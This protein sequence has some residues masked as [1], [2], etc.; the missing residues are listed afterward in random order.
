M[1]CYYCHQPATVHRSDIVDKEKRE[2]H[3]CDGCARGHCHYCGQPATDNGRMQCRADADNGATK[4]SPILPDTDFGRIADGKEDRNH[5][6]AQGPDETN[7]LD[8]SDD[9]QCE[10]DMDC[11][12]ADSGMICLNGACA[13]G[14]R[15]MDGNG[16]AQGQR[17]TSVNGEAGMC[18]PIVKPYFGGG[19]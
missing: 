6:G 4:T 5:D 2:M 8:P 7:P 15:G 9:A 3:L 19:G 16:C 10:I 12:A 13:P 14:C 18:V 1:N 11:G 17:C